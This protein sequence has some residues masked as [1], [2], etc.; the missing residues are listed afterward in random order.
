MR[1][2]I[3]AAGM[4]KR[5][6]P[7]GWDQ[8]KGLLRI[9]GRTLLD[10][11]IESLL[12]NEVRHVVA[13]V[14]YQREVIEAAIRAHPVDA[15]FVVN[16][17]YAETN[18]IHSLWLARDY[19]DDEFLYFNA[20]VFFDRRIVGLLLEYETSALAVEAK[21]CGEEEVKVSVDAEGRIRRIGKALPPHECLGEF[22]GIARFMI[23]NI[24]LLPIS[25]LYR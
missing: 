23:G 9:G 17:D 7:M 10:N 13:V 18:T 16:E 8:P 2:V 24:A 25:V 22:I 12:E 14:G 6:A 3:L 19:L 1:A 11:N 4:G 5:L 15:A 21:S 20:D